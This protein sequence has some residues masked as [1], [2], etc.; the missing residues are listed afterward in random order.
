M[1]IEWRSFAAPANSWVLGANVFRAGQPT[2]AAEVLAL[3][4]N[5][6]N[7]EGF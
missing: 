6:K 2:A 4:A 1:T 3:G 7:N 5:R